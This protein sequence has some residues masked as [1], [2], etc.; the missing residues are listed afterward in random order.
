MTANKRDYEKRCASTQ[1]SFLLV[2]MHRHF[3]YTHVHA[4][5][6]S[7]FVT[8]TVL[9]YVSSTLHMQYQRLYDLDVHPLIQ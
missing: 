4:D 7:G 8:V 2:H 9:A 6:L 5:V 1:P 3:A